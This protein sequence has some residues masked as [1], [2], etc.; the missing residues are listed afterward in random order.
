MA[1]VPCDMCGALTRGHR[2]HDCRWGNGYYCTCP[3]PDVDPVDQC[4]RCLRAHKATVYRR[5]GW[6]LEETA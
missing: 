6:T 2:C 1:T 5:Y 4:R 3:V